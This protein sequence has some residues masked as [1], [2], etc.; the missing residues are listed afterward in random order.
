MPS[1]RT[2]PDYLEGT[3]GMGRKRNSV[4]PAPRKQRD[5]EVGRVNLTEMPVELLTETFSYLELKD[6]VNL[7]RVNRFFCDLMLNRRHAHMWRAAREQVVGLPDLPP[8]LSE[9]AFARLL[10][11]KLCHGC[12]IARVEK[13]QWWCFKRYCK[14]CREKY[15]TGH[16]PP[17]RVLL[18]D[19]E[20]FGYNFDGILSIFKP[21][22]HAELYHKPQFRQFLE[23]RNATEDSQAAKSQLYEDQKA[24][25]AMLRKHAEVLEEW[26]DEVQKKRSKELAFVSEQRY[27]DICTRLIDEGWGAEV[28]HLREGGKLYDRFPIVRESSKLTDAGFR[29]VLQKL[30]PILQETR[31][32]LNGE[33]RQR[34]LARRLQRLRDA[35]RAFYVQIPRQPSMLW[36]PTRGDL[37]HEP[38]TKRLIL[39]PN[40]QNVTYEDFASLIPIVG[41]R[42]EEAVKAKLRSTVREQVEGIPDD[43]DPL[44]LAVASFECHQCRNFGAGPQY[45]PA[46]VA[47]SCF[48]APL[49]RSKKEPED[50]LHIA[51]LKLSEDNQPINMRQ[52]EGNTFWRTKSLLAELQLPP[53]T[54][55]LQDVEQLRLRWARWEDRSVDTWYTALANPPPA[56]ALP[57]IQFWRFATAEECAEAA[58]VPER[59]CDLP[60][61]R[62]RN[63]EWA[64]ALCHDGSGT[65]RQMADHLSLNISLVYASRHSLFDV[66][67]CVADG[68]VFLHPGKMDVKPS[69]RLPDPD[70]NMDPVRIEW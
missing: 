30:T 2:N 19:G 20:Y 1:V 36:R 18:K 65:I 40:E 6:F 64:C 10:Y 39:A 59:P 47:H 29:R 51:L 22:R 38:E 23:I 52:L 41:P 69:V 54:T 5:R 67:T 70:K 9:P 66:N 46:L 45:Y 50:E 4:V 37:V 68:D 56:N 16:W 8:F 26:A 31:A 61:A 57:E 25:I 21:D 42:W 53:A 32:T 7:V 13:V 34:V 24:K 15:I 28:E 48:R 44:N 27:E 33:R 55:T 12:G 11:S 63:A 49:H 35:I 43:V 60:T 62:L 14:P 3:S 58:A 17:T